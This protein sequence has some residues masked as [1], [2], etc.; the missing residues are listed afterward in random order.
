MKLLCHFW[1][2]VL[3]LALNYVLKFNLPPNFEA[4]ELNYAKV[5]SL[6]FLKQTI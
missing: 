5:W 2:I 3:N 1:E 4:I 6:Y